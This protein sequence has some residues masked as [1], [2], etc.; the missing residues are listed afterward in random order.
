MKQFKFLLLFAVPALL[1]YCCGAF[2]YYRYDWRP[3][4]TPIPALR[5]PV[6]AEFTADMTDDYIVMIEFSTA[7]DRDY[8]ECVF[9]IDVSPDKCKITDSATVAWKI[10]SGSKTIS[11]GLAEGPERGAYSR[12]GFSTNTVTRYAA[13]AGKTY[14]IEIMLKAPDSTIERVKPF[15]KVAPSM[16]RH[17]D[18]S[19]TFGLFQAASLGL[20]ILAAISFVWEFV[21]YRKRSRERR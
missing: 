18:A 3:V 11:E 9:G 7:K 13:E 8:W 15:L 19:V 1:A 10:T 17:K 12:A 16:R 4:S 14:R 21:H 5:L 20:G 6:S 2:L